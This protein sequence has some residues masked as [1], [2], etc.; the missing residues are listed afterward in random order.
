MNN[1]LNEQVYDTKIGG[2]GETQAIANMLEQ[3]DNGS[4]EKEK[5]EM[6]ISAYKQLNNRQKN[7]I[8][9]QRVELKMKQFELD[10]SEKK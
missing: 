5:L 1:V 6:K 7:I 9:A 8:D 2:V 3:I 10:N 4:I